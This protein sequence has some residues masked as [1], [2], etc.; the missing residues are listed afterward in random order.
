MYMRACNLIV[1]IYGSIKLWGNLLHFS[2]NRFGVGVCQ[3][4]DFSNTLSF[5]LKY[6]LAMSSDY[7]E[8]MTRLIWYLP[9]ILLVKVQHM[10][11]HRTE[12]TPYET[13]SS[14]KLRFK[15]C[16]LSCHKLVRIDNPLRTTLTSLDGLLHDT[17]FGQTGIMLR[18]LLR[19]DDSKFLSEIWIKQIGSS[20][21]PVKIKS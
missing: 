1:R 20:L 18:I 14:H 10:Q 12:L 5:M 4:N 3:F 17:S 6:F 21:P 7:E 2:Y 9:H 19:N 15:F 16:V 8:I 11:T 13:Q